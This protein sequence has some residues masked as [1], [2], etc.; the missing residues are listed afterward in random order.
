MNQQAESPLLKRIRALMAMA[1]DKS[2]TEAEAALF[3]AK[4][5]ELLATHGLQMADVRAVNEESV[6]LQDHAQTKWK[7]PARRKLLIAV[8]R[9][10]MCDVLSPADKYD[11]WTFVGRPAN[12][13]VAIEMVDYLIKTVVRLSNEYGKAN[14]RK[15]KH[16]IDFRRGAMVRLAQR[17]AILR[18]EALEKKPE[19]HGTNPGNL[20]ALF[21]SEDALI[22]K[23]TE[24]MALKANKP[25]A[26][27]IGLDALH[28][29]RAA[30][31]IG[32]HEQVTGPR[33]AGRLAIGK[34]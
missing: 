13:T 22:E 19:W 20:P 6:G 17:L 31:D 21:A 14:G 5:Q 23:A 10:Y 15:Q 33:G 30:N 27:K 2:T 3:A 32:L 8:C 28:G 12:V 25:R 9:Y 24:H 26:L 18:A 11:T 4:V 29:I 1:N 7:S 34:D 16:V